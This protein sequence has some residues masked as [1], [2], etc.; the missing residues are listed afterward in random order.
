MTT[1]PLAWLQTRY[2]A[3]SPLAWTVAML[4]ALLVAAV[5]RAL[6]RN[7]AAKGGEAGK[8]FVSANPVDDPEAA[9][10]PAGHLYWGFLHAMGRYYKRMRAFHSG[11]LPDYVLW[12]VLTLGCLFV[13]L[14]LAA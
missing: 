3:W 10:V 7:D 6:G 1:L 13:G 5:L 4:V 12:F 14:L 11:I 8:P 9:R 2:G